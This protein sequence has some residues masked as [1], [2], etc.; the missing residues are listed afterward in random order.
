MERH[1]T[2]LHRAARALVL[3][4]SGSDGFDA[5]APELQERAIESVKA[6]L[7]AIREP[8]EGM[9]DAAQTSEA[10]SWTAAPGEGLDA[11]HWDFAW[12]AMIDAAIAED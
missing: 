4:E 12:Q 10:L 8:S 7:Q 1:M 5:M 9:H 6:V 3:K 2:P 11:V